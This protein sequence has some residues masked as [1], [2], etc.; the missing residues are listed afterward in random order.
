M[1]K[2]EQIIMV[3][4]RD[5]LFAEQYFNGFSK[6]DEY[7]YEKIILKNLTYEKRGLAEVT[8]SLKQPVGYCLIV[9]PEIKKVFAYQ[10]SKKDKEYGEKRLQGKW[11]WGIG[12]HMERTDQQNSDNP[13][14]ASML[15]E[16]REE[17][18]FEGDVTFKVLG[19]INDDETPVGK[20]HFG[21]L[22]LILT[23]ATEI[24]ANAHEIAHGG[25]VDLARIK[26]ILNSSDSEVESWSEIAADSL[27]DILA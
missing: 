4:P 22:Y 9:N 2:N 23:N 8:P 14:E 3:V 6:A 13:I 11:S 17:V 20:V 25:F 26:E 27:V 12:G 10:R 1:N 19:Y 7:D 15:R 24:H 18:S 21:V 16:L 5:I